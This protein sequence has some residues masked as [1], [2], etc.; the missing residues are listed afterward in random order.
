MCAYKH[1]ETIEYVKNV[2]YLLRK[3]QTLR[4]NNSKILRIKNAKF[5][6]Y[7]FYMNPNIIFELC[8]IA[9]FSNL[10]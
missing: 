2:A 5:S 7:C 6:R 10:H 4:D 9:K 1:T 8:E 3:I